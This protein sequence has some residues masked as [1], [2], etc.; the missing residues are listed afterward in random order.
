MK[1]RKNYKDTEKYRK[2]RYNY[3]K[4]YYNKTAYAI[5]HKMRWNDGEIEMV[6]ERKYTDTQLAKILGRSV[7]AIQGMRFKVNAGLR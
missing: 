5:N 2:Y 4:R 3:N 1:C 7:R 6:M